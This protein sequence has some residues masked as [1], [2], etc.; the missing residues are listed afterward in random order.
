MFHSFLNYWSKDIYNV[1]A[2]RWFRFGIFAILLFQTIVLC[3][4]VADL[5]W[6]VDSLVKSVRYPNTWTYNF[7]MALHHG[8][9][10][11]YYPYLIAVQLVGLILGIM[12]KFTRISSILVYVT[13]V[14]LFNRVYLVITGG[15]YLIHIFLF[16]L[17]FVNE[18]GKR[19]GINAFLSNAF[20]WACRIQVI[21]VYFFAS[22]YKL[23][24]ETWMNGSALKY[25]LNMQEFSLPFMVGNMGNMDWL[26]TLGTY[27]SL[28]YQL[29]FPMLVWFKKIKIPYL[30]LG[31]CFHVATIV[32]MGIP[33][34]GLIMIVSYII[35]LNDAELKGLFSTKRKASSLM[36]N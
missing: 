35:F 18:N 8:N 10:A 16:Y 17:I 19:A 27:L 30:I 14:L 15:N 23:T 20:I 2:I 33:V 32:I 4:P 3:L 1:Q 28:G 36:T 21:Y 7:Y 25:L 9:F 34:F 12:R 24:G 29:F 22:I 5:I 11:S 26:L 31:V 13:T 6:G